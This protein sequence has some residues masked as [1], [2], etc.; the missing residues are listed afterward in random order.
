MPRCTKNV[1]RGDGNSVS[2]CNSGWPHASALLC[3][4]RNPVLVFQYMTGHGGQK[5]KR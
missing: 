1:V 2:G 5:L 3:E 4:N